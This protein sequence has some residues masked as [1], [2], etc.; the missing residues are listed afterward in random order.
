MT[1]ENKKYVTLD[2]AAR[3]VGLKRSSLYY[4]IKRLNIE[5]KEF[6]F[7]RHTWISRADLERIKAAKESPWKL[8]EDTEKREAVK[9]PEQDAA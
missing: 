8:E 1:E 9:K 5:R 7:N 4:Y 2:E 6:P 3:T